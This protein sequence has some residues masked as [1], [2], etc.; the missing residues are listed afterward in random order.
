MNF[1]NTKQAADY[2]KATYNEDCKAV[3]LGQYRYRTK[4]FGRQFGPNWA[5]KGYN[6]VVYTKE[7]LDNW[8][9]E[10]NYVPAK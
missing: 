4:K 7:D 1:L 6:R 5:N 8:A 3:T 10:M 9:K 2:I